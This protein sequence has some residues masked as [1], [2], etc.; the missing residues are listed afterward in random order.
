MFSS[1]IL[2]WYCTSGV[3]DFNKLYS[4]IVMM[5]MML[6]K[7]VKQ[8]VIMTM[9]KMILKMIIVYLDFVTEGRQ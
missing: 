7:M 1:G 8:V 3:V 4:Y 6:V 9:V 2:Y 5:K